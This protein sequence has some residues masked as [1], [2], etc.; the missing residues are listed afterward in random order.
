MGNWCNKRTW[1]NVS[2]K[3][4]HQSQQYD[5]PAKTGTDGCGW[6]LFLLVD[7]TRCP[8]SGESQRL[9]PCLYWGWFYHCQR[10]YGPEWYV[11]T[12]G[13]RRLK[14]AFCIY[15]CSFDHSCCCF[16][17]FPS[18]VKEQKGPSADLLFNRIKRDLRANAPK[19]GNHCPPAAFT[20]HG[21]HDRRYCPWI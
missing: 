16:L 6:I 3:K 17:Y 12:F 11:C 8:G 18:D 21:N 5:R 13:K 20:D 19:W 14:T 9:Y 2:R 7:Q 4:S 1:K 15:R 10:C